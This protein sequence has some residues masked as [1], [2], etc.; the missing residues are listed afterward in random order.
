MK[1]A[2]II[3]VPNII[4]PLRY[5]EWHSSRDDVKKIMNVEQKNH[6]CDSKAY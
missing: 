3:K 6:V 1:L 5:D 2:V 4:I